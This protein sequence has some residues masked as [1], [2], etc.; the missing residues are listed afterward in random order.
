MSSGIEI[1]RKF[2]IDIDSWQPKHDGT[3]IRQGYLSV[4]K[5]RTVRVRQ[6]GERGYITVK[7]ATKGFSRVELEYEIPVQD[8]IQMLDSLCLRPLV[9]KTRYVEEHEG[10]KWEIDV[11]H[12]D[13]DGLVIAEAELSSEE[14]ELLL[15]KWITKEITGDKRFYNSYLSQVPYSQWR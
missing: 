10:Q 15:P 11:F 13:N 7:G 2:F 6:K 3:S 1:E 5:E 12:G 8:A 9:E 4:D 14:Q